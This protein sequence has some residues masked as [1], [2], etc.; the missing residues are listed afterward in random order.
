MKHTIQLTEKQW[1]SIYEDIAK[2]Y[3]PS[4]LLIRERMKKVLGFTSRRHRQWV[5]SKGKED[6][7]GR[8]SKGHWEESIMLDFYSEKKMSWFRLK[9]SEY[10][11]E[12]K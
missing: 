11:N 1:A 6:W 2:N 9:F 12:S 4:V 3:P 10:L 7:E 5:S 8:L